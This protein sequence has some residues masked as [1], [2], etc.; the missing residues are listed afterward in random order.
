[1]KEVIMLTEI[2]GLSYEDCA[3]RLKCPLGTVKSRIYNAKKELAVKL[4]D[5]M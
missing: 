4:Q 1:M 3:A 2:E 5:L